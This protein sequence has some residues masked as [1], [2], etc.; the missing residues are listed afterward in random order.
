M[1]ARDE[2]RRRLRR[3]I[4]PA[5]GALLFRTTAPIGKNWG[6]DRGTP[7][8]RFYIEG[9]LERYGRDIRGRVLE[10]K[11]ASYTR[12]FGSG[13]T[14]S[15]VLD[16][17]RAN[18]AATI[19]TDLAAADAIPSESFDCVILT[20]TLQFVLDVRSALA[21]LHRLLAPDGVVLATTPTLSR[22]APRGPEGIDYW[23]F[24]PAACA[25]LFAA[26]FGG[27]NVLVEPLGNVLS[28]IAF[29]H[30]LAAEE[31]PETK[32]EQH[33]PDFPLVVGVRALKRS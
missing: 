13:V 29:L 4:L 9:F 28:G 30:G 24:T 31:L 15:D 6:W 11:D 5:R 32:L 21:H 2:A 26:E 17:N 19:Y 22:L 16:I 23:R 18:A 8:D 3:A 25:A 27:E 7:V 14:K 20:Q 1:G 33:D 10:I 12:R